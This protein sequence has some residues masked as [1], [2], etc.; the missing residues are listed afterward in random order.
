MSKAVDKSK[1]NEFL[2]EYWS[3]PANLARTDK[4][5]LA[6]GILRLNNTPSSASL[7]AGLEIISYNSSCFN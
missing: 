7:G 1:L 5:P 4:V 6:V 2:H 3:N